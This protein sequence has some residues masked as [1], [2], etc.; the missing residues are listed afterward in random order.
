MLAQLII[1]ARYTVY[2]RS[3]TART[4]Q[5]FDFGLKTEEGRCVQ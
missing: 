1:C 4:D 2:E 5:C 3:S